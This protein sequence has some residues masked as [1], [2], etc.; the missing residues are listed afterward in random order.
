MT[1]TYFT[2]PASQNSEEHIRMIYV[3][4]TGQCGYSSTS[5]PTKFVYFNKPRKG[6]SLSNITKVDGSAN[7]LFVRQAG[8]F[9]VSLLPQ[10]TYEQTYC[11]CDTLSQ[12]KPLTNCAF[13]F[14]HAVLRAFY[15]IHENP[16]DFYVLNS[17]TWVQQI[18]CTYL[19]IASTCAMSDQCK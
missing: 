3:F 8:I 9:S 13:F 1:K 12:E 7:M 18:E 2:C 11:I 4:P 6:H 15:E 10:C 5:A 14:V 16:N 17:S 19:G